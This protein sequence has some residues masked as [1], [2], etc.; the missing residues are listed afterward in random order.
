MSKNR[1]VMNGGLMLKTPSNQNKKVA[2]YFIKIGPAF[3][4]WW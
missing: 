2:C 3:K 4:I 1:M